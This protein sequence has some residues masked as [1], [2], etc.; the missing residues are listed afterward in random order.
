MAFAFNFMRMTP[1]MVGLAAK[2]M[3]VVRLLYPGEGV[4]EPEMM[5]ALKK[6]RTKE[7]MAF[8]G[9]FTAKGML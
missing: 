2:M 4:K 9:A 1:A 5:D 8:S 6:V 7:L 3:P